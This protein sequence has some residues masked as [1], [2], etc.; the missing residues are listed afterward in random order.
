MTISH[1]DS[2]AVFCLDGQ[3][4]ALAVAS[5]ERVVHAVE[6]APLPGAP[7]GVRGVVNFRGTV[8]PVFDLRVR[9]GQA[10][11][12]VQITDNLVIANT[13]RRKVALMV[14]A[15][16]SVVAAGEAGMVAAT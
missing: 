1:P 3:Q 5:V 7:Q 11:R 2:L 13:A 14:D 9:F 8:V 10:G 15:A 12:E 6:I 16:V 4:F